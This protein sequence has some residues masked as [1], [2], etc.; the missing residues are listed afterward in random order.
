MI[1][2]IIVL[3][4]CVVI[5]SGL[6]FTYGKNQSSVADDNKL[7]KTND[8][9]ILKTA[10][11][12]IERYRKGDG[13]IT[14]LQANHQPVTNAKVVIEQ[15]SH[16]FLF[17]SNIHIPMITMDEASPLQ[18]SFRQKFLEV[19]NYATLP[20]YWSMFEPRQGKPIFKELEKTARWYKEQGVLLKGH[21]LVWHQTVPNWVNLDK[22]IASLLQQR[23]TNIVT[24][25]KDLIDCWDVINESTIPPLKKNGTN[26][27]D[28]WVKKEGSANAA[29]LALDWAYQANPKAFLVVNDFRLASEYEQQ[30]QKLKEQKAHFNAIG[31]QSHMHTEEWSLTHLWDV[32]E[33]YGRFGLPLHFTEVTVLSGDY[34]SVPNWQLEHNN[35]WRTTSE[36]ESKQAEYVPKL[37]K[38]LF[39]H[40]AVTVITWWNLT[41]YSAWKGAP[42]GLLRKDMSEKPA[43]QKLLNLIKKDWWTKI[44]GVTDISGKVKFRG[45][46]GK[47]RITVIT[48]DGKIHQEEKDFFKDKQ[49]FVLNI[50]IK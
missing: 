43:Y 9:K 29:H 35:S 25:Y 38:L 34:Q 22:P 40:P 7:D 42:A 49:P 1:Y 26:A 8:D 16:E 36:G 15:I 23:V 10:D 4:I 28:L 13:V 46:F 39:S 32:C 19:F 48:P 12:R 18:K 33:T 30:L 45:F 50:Y 44:E 24:Y 11:E 37:Y 27:V 2:K 6:V 20:F 3:I 21:P 47:Y 31:I 14:V 41:D 17:G 5:L